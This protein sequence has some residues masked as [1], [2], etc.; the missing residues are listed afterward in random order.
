VTDVYAA[1]A[2]P[3]QAARN[4]ISHFETGE[5]IGRAE[6]NRLLAS[7]SEEEYARLAPDLESVS[8]DARQILAA[9]NES[10]RYVYFLRDALVSLLVDVDD[11]ST[12]EGAVI[13]NEGVIGLGVFLGD[14]NSTDHIAVQVAGGAARITATAFR[15]AIRQGPQLQ[16]LLQ[17]YA[18]AL[19]HQIART[20]ACNRLHSVQQRCARWLLMSDDRLHRGTFPLTHETLAIL[21]GVRRAS[22]SEAVETLQ[23]Q[24]CIAYQR[25]RMSI[26]DRVGLEAAVCEDYRRTRDAYNQ[27]YRRVAAHH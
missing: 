14:G 10:I 13:G 12:M 2:T 15:E 3:A 8:V 21:L 7:L 9:P 22:V 26:V 4:G 24:G 5:P 23:R 18:L 1:P 25:G 19:M 6:Q 11:G 27:I 16:S 17:Q 20:A